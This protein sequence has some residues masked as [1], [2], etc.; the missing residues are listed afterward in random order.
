MEYLDFNG[1]LQGTNVPIRMGS[2]EN[3]LSLNSYQKILGNIFDTIKVGL[4]CH[5]IVYCQ[6]S[7]G[8]DDS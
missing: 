2:S 1:R 6:L 3:E 8:R 4:L 5:N 7:L